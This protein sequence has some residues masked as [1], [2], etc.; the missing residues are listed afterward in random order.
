MKRIFLG[1]LKSV[2]AGREKEKKE[3]TS[4]A[5]G[6]MEGFSSHLEKFNTR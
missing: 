3:E 4:G 1:G 5:E 2:W 6:I